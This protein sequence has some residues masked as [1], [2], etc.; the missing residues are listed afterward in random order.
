MNNMKQ[1]IKISTLLIVMATMLSSCVDFLGVIPK[2]QKIPTTW[3]DYNA[4]IRNNYTYHY[5]D[6]DQLGLLMGDMFKVPSAVSSPSLTRTHYYA[7]ESANR[8]D[9]MAGTDKNPYFNAYEGLFAWNLIV[10][11]VPE[12]T[13]CTQAQREMLIAQGRVLRAMHYFYLTNYYADQYCEATKNKLS[14][15]LLTSASVEAPSPQVT[16]Q[17]MYEFLLDDLNKAAGDALPVNAE[18]I[19]HPNRALGYG[20]L[21]RVYLSMG[22]YEN[23]LKN[24]SLALQQND[25][26]FNWVTFYEADKARYDAPNSYSTRVKGNPEIDNVENYIYGYG[27]FTSGWRGLNNTNYAISPERAARFEQGDTRL[28]THWKSRFSASGIHYYAGIYA[29]EMNRGGMRSPEMYYIK[30]ECLARKGGTENIKEAMS[31]VNKVRKTRILPEY[32]EDW[33]ASSTKEA[34]EKI[35][36]DKESEYIQS[37]VIFCD[38]RR[39]NKDPDYARE[40]PRTIEGVEYVLKPDSHLWIMPF[41]REAVS[42]PG[43]GTITQNVEK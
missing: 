43:N 42:N 40:F 35:I 38:Y 34:V 15:P 7:D 32:Y 13:E 26:L 12:A 18:T 20:M 29:L 6:P 16:I 23:A 25:K 22:D 5:L 21:A 33:S 2:G 8:I 14:V 37:Q 31:L 19:L 4:F 1:I 41:P 36:R 17:E 30:A 27:S 3:E 28:L 10:E 11:N 9:L 39:L 24:A